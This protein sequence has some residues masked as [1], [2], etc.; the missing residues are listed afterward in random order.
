MSPGSC[1]VVSFPDT[2][3]ICSPPF[4]LS[5]FV[6]W[7]AVDS[8][9]NKVR[10]RKLTLLWDGFGKLVEGEAPTMGET[11]SLWLDTNIRM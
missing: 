3:G 1:L 9:G 11:E 2:P 8:T 5:F 4:F 10:R 6:V 7:D